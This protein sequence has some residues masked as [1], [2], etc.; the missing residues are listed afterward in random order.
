MNKIK[1]L[2]VK[3]NEEPKIIEIENTE[4]SFKDIVS[5]ELEYIKL[6]KK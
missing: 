2:L 6:K 5:G 3:P 4:D 1:V